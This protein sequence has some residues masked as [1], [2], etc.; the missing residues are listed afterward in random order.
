VHDR[1]DFVYAAGDVTTLESRIVGEKR[2]RL[3]DVAVDPWPSD[4]R[5]VVSTFRVVPALRCWSPPTRGS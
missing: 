2:N 4:H 5:A 1:I 3:V